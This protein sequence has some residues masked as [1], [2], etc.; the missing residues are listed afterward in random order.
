MSA[1]VLPFPLARRL[2]L[3][4]RQADYALCLKPAKAEQH[5]ERQLQ[6]QREALQRR[7]VAAEII[8][9]EIADMA[10]AIYYAMWVLTSE[11]PDEA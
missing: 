4:H 3:I 5:I 6:C 10:K 11:A 8:E 2:D 7:G 9:R 1:V